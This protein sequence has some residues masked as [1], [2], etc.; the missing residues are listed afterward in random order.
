MAKK[1][2][3]SNHNKVSLREFLVIGRPFWWVNTA[4]PFVVSYFIIGGQTDWLL[5]FGIFY[6]AFVYNVAMY[7]I[8]DIYDYESDIKNP[9]KTGID[10]SVLPKAKHS[11]LWLKISIISIP[12]T[13]AMFWAG[14]LAANVWLAV[15]IFMV[16]AYSVKGLRFKEIP[17]LDSITSSFHYT[18]PFI[19]GGLLASNIDLHVPAFM[20]FF[21]W[22]MANHA[23]GAIQDIAPDKAAGISSIATKLG[24]E[25]TISFV[26]AAYIVAM[27]LP[28]MFYGTNALIVS[29]GLLPYALIVLRTIP[30]RANSNSVLFKQGWNRFLYINY[31]VGFVGTILLLIHFNVVVL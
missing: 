11:D 14:N 12:A 25:L 7:G 31:I 26:L 17:V 27:I 28:V 8:N 22:V 29:L 5:Y 24:S 1:I 16:L 10:G 18:S 2:I 13:I 30:E 15:M 9:R 6:F 23:F 20:V 4:V 3:K 19:Y 21:V